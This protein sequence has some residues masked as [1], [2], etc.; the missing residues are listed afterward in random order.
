MFMDTGKYRPLGENKTWNESK[1]RFIFATTENEENIFLETFLRRI[2][3][4]VT[5][6]NFNNRPLAE[7]IQLIKYMFYQEANILQKNILVKGESVQLLLNSH[8]NGNIG[9]L[10]NMIKLSCADAYN[11]HPD[12]DTLL[13]S[14]GTISDMPVR[15]AETSKY[16]HNYLLIEYAFPF[17]FDQEHADGFMLELKKIMSDAKGTGSKASLEQLKNR[18]QTLHL[19]SLGNFS[20][21]ENIS[22]QSIMYVKNM[23]IQKWEDIIMNRYGIVNSV[24]IDKIS[25]DFYYYIHEKKIPF[26]GC[27]KDLD[28]E[29]QTVYPRTSYIADK[30]V[31]SLH[32]TSEKSAFLKIVISLLLS[33]YVKE[34]IELKGLLIAHGESTASSIQSVVNRLCETYVFEAIDMPINTALENIITEARMFIHHQANPDGLILLVDMGSLSK[35]YSSIK[36]ALQGDLLI[37]DNLTTSNALDIGLKIKNRVPFKTIAEQSV[38]KY[39]IET[40]YFEGFSKTKNIIISCMSGMGI[41]EKIKDIM[42]KYLST[43]KIEVLTMEYRELKNTIDRN[44]KNYF[45]KTKLVITTTDLP[46]S[47]SIPHVNIYNMLDAEGISN[48][49]SLIY[50]DI[51]RNSFD[52]MIQELLKLFSIQGVVDRLKFLNPVVVINEVENVLTKYENYYRITFTGKVKLNLYMHIALMIERLFIS[53]EE[54][55]DIKEK[56]SE[57]EAEFYV[58]SKNIFKPM[59]NNYNIMVSQYEISLLYQLIGPFIQK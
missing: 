26:L 15:K 33:D 30:F 46:S 28:I 5:I 52:K 21:F 11:H 39:K 27:L 34:D 36:N 51:S 12:H 47:F 43:E 57:P 14:P 19:K 29:I 25:F 17:D 1:V 22:N 7:K 58:T 3:V 56:L 4:H 9:K 55:E 38:E 18:L 13:I 49:W 10:K 42:S 16:P 20:Y 8:F 2:Q 37:V 41:S 59:E 45:D 31:S 35:L 23:F 24:S 50:N 54:K 44:S 40:Q 53:R 32:L 48:L 6:S